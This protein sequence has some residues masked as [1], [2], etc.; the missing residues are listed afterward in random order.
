MCN[1]IED[2]IEKARHYE[3]LWH[4]ALDDNAR[5]KAEVERLRTH[6]FTAEELA[7]MK[8]ETEL[9][10]AQFKRDL[11]NQVVEENERLTK[12][13]ENTDCMFAMASAFAHD[14]NSMKEGKPSV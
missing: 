8:A 5:L 2:L 14:W 10:H 1:R 6:S 13:L 4:E 9:L 3:D 11:F 12:E 7:S